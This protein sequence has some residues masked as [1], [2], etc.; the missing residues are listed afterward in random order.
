MTRNNDE[1]ARKAQGSP[2][3]ILEIGG[4]LEWLTQSLEAVA[5]GEVGLVFVVHDNKIVR[6]KKVTEESHLANRG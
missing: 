6:V 4:D 5:F 2:G 1:S 3:K